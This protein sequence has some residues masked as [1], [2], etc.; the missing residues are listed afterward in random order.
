MTSG[1]AEAAE[2]RGI[3]NEM[4]LRPAV[5]PQDG[6]FFAVERPEPID[7]A[8]E[9]P[10]QIEAIREMVAEGPVEQP[11]PL[12]EALAEVFTDPA[13]T[14]VVPEVAAAPAP[15]ATPIPEVAPA[16]APAAEEAPAVEAAP[17]PEPTTVEATVAAAD[18]AESSIDDMFTDLG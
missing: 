15:E 8:V 14:P 11:A 5:E 4:I 2:G 12:G 3:F 7:F 10:E 16:P 13:P 17:A 9:R 18:Q 1:L 6:G